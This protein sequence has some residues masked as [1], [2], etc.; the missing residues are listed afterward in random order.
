MVVYEMLR[1][2]CPPLLILLVLLISWIPGLYNQGDLDYVEY[3]AGIGM[4]A[5]KC[6]QAAWMCSFAAF[7]KEGL[8]NH[9]NAHEITDRFACARVRILSSCSTCSCRLL[10]LSR[11]I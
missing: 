10:I 5:E 3:M 11:Q 8:T 6:A 7:L 1:W 2:R 9:V 4:V